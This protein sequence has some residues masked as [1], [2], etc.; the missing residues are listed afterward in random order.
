[1]YLQVHYGGVDH[2]DFATKPAFSYK[3]LVYMIGVVVPSYTTEHRY[4]PFGERTSKGECLFHINRIK[5][6]FEILLELTR[7]F[8]HS[9]FLLIHSPCGCKKMELVNVDSLELNHATNST[10]LERIVVG[11]V[12]LIER[13]ST[14]HQLI[15]LELAVLIQ[16]K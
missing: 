5:G 6:N 8:W 2:N 9:I 1:M 3:D 10:P 16:G 11:L 7:R 12:N 13:V 15:Q 4:I 14:R